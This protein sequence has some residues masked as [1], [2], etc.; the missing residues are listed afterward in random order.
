MYADCIKQGRLRDAT[1]DELANVLITLDGLGQAVKREALVTLR[2]RWI[3][4]GA[5][6]CEVVAT[7]DK[8]SID[9]PKQ[10]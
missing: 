7:W 10:I 8:K 5:A 4:D 3:R 9:I 1:D 2:A 6:D